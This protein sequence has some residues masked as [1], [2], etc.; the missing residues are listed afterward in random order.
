[1]EQHTPKKRWCIY[2]LLCYVVGRVSIVGI[3]TTTDW[4]VRGS[5]PIGG[6]DIF[7]TRPD[8]L[9]GPPSLLYN[10]YQVSFPRVKPPGRGVDLPSPSRAEVQRK[11][12]DVTPLSVLAFVACFRVNITFCWSTGRRSIAMHTCNAIHWIAGFM[13]QSH[14]SCTSDQKTLPDDPLIS[15]RYPSVVKS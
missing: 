3:A 9:R 6:G 13:L 4:T 8:R 5:N 14:S 15:T 1:M 11:S 10:C 7:P 12:R 2:R